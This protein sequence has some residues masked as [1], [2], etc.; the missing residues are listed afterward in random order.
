MVRNLC[1]SS[2]DAGAMSTGGTVATGGT[3]GTGGKG[4]TAGRT[5]DGGAGQGGGGGKV[6]IC[7]DPVPNCT[8][9]A[10]AGGLC[11]PVC[12]KG[13]GACDQKCSVNSAGSL[14]CNPLSSPDN[15]VGILANCFPSMS[16]NDPATQSD[17]CQPGTA[18]VNHN[19]CASRCYKFCRK[20]TDCPTGASCSIDAG[21]GKSFCDVPLTQCDPVNGA[22]M[23]L[24]HSGCPNAIQSCYL[25]EDSPNNSGNTVCD[26]YNNGTIHAA[27]QDCVHSRDCYGGLVCADLTGHGKKCLKVCRLPSPDG[28]ADLT[29]KDAGEVG[30]GSTDYHN[31]I[32]ILLPN[33]SQTTVFG[34][35]NE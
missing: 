11:D 30:C 35:C 28:G 18:C 2:S 13:C 10:D 17:N 6:T 3:V 8:T 27:G 12:N 24:G 32:P 31:C 34:A 22:A 26:C 15:T 4:G 21:S 16:G 7:L 19:A 23:S 14:T 25:L 9:P 1:V 5:V 20:S 29:R 33:G